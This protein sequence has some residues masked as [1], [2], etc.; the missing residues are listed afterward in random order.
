[1]DVGGKV[2]SSPAVANGVVYVASGPDLFA[3]DTATGAQLW[4]APVGG[5]DSVDSPPSIF[6]G[7]VY[8]GSPDATLYAFRLPAG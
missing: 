6:D 8:F 4:S 5:I 7:S 1:M 3:L 2:E